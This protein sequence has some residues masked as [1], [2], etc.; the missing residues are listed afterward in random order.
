MLGELV[1]ERKQVLAE[2]ADVKGKRDSTSKKKAAAVKSKPLIEYHMVKEEPV[3]QEPAAPV[4]PT[5]AER[6]Y[7]LKKRLATLNRRIGAYKWTAALKGP[8]MTVINQLTPERD[9]IE[10]ELASIKGRRK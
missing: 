5:I 3:K 2:L 4:E 7:A 9:Q 6:R 1:P 10:A 8:N